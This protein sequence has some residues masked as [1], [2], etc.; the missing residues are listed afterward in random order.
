M[1]IR[2]CST[3]LILVDFWYIVFGTIPNCMQVEL[4][5][6]QFVWGPFHIFT[7]L[8]SGM[9]FSATLPVAT[10]ECNAKALE[11]Q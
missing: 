1:Q 9:D 8:Y 4:F 11:T 5:L 2:Y 6:L 7:G 10:N 3:S